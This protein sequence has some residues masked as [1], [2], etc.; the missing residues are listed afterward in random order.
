M[1]KWWEKYLDC[2]DSKYFKSHCKN[3]KIIPFGNYCLPRVITTINRLKPTKKC[4]EESFPFDLCFSKFK[5]NISL[6]ATNFEEFFDDI[7]FDDKEKWWKNDKTNMC[8]SHDFLAKKDFIE[9]YQKRIENFYKVLNNTQI[10]IYFVIATVEIVTQQ[11]INLFVDLINKHRENKTYDVII[12]NQTDVIQKFNFENVHCI[13]L[14]ND[15]SFEIINKNRDWV[16][17]LKKMKSIQA[18]IFNHKV[19][20]QLSKIIKNKK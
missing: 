19:I 12:I 5:S 6:L 2:I 11:E 14:T 9:R 18:R 17:E 20:Y 13:N 4:G 7:Y 1:N 3:Y 15:K 16:S 8:F 10:H